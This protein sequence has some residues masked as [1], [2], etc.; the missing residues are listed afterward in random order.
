MKKTPTRPEPSPVWRAALARFDGDLRRRGAAEK[1]RRAYGSDLGDLAGWATAAGIEPGAVSTRVLRRW[2][3]G[4]SEAGAAPATVARR[5]ASTRA[6]FRSM[7]EHGDVAENP[8]D[9]L[10]APKRPSSL[11][12]VLKPAALSRLLD[13]I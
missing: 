6:F 8:A 10:G 11:P 9:L 12:K 7:R 5:L 1:T 2:A 13:R 3:A 4:L